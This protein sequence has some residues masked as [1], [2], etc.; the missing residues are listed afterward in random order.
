MVENSESTVILLPVKSERKLIA[1]ER[2]ANTPCAQWP[3]YTG[4]VT[5]PCLADVWLSGSFS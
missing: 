5:G 3:E 1:S 4:S 2:L